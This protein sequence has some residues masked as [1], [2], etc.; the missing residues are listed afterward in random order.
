MPL[1]YPVTWPDYPL[2][3]ITTRIG[4][5]SAEPEALFS[6]PNQCPSP[7]RRVPI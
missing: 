3:W 7:P 4:F 1:E 2:R 6:L 5:L